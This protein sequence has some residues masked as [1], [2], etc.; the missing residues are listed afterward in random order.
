MQIGAMNKTKR[1]NIHSLFMF[2]HF[3]ES[4]QFINI[5]LNELVLNKF[6][7]SMQNNVW[8]TLVFDTNSMG[9]SDFSVEMQ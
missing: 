4:I 2:L 7:E 1:N 5:A 9:S 8:T 6:H 3:S